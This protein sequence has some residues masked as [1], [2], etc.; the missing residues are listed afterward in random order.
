MKYWKP[1]YSS[2]QKEQRDTVGIELKTERN[3]EG[4]KTK[5]TLILYGTEKKSWQLPLIVVI[6]APILCINI[7]IHIGGRQGLPPPSQ[8][9]F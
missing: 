7:V 2:H 9:F 1:T 4:I 5:G 6:I 3:Q 8:L